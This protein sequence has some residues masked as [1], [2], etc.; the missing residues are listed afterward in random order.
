M[1]IGSDHNAPTYTTDSTTL[2]LHQ[3]G[4]KLHFDPQSGSL[5]YSNTQGSKELLSDSTFNYTRFQV[6]TKNDSSLRI[7]Y[8]DVGLRCLVIFKNDLEIKVKFESTEPQTLCWPKVSISKAKH[9]FIWPK[10]GGY[11]IPFSDTLFANKFDG[12]NVNATYLSL[13]FWAVEK[14]SATSM[15]EMVNPFHT[16]ILFDN[17]DSTMSLRVF[18]RYTSNAA[19]KEPYEIKIIH[20]SNHSPITPALHF[21]KQLE[22]SNDLVSLAQKIESV[23]V[24]KRMIGALY[25]KLVSIQFITKYDIR[26]GKCIALA[27]AIVEDVQ[28]HKGFVA[29]HWKKLEPNQRDF[30][31][32]IAHSEKLNKY[33]EKVFIQIL[34]ALLKE[35]GVND[36]FAKDKRKNAELLY[37]DYSEYLLPPEQWG[38]GVSIRMINALEDAGINR[39]ILR[40]LGH[41]IAFDRK[42]VAK[43]AFDQGYLFGVYD[44]YLSIHDLSTYGTDDSWET[45][46]MPEVIFD[47]V[48]M[49]Q[50]NGFHYP[51]FK[52]RGGI[53]NPKVIRSYYEKRINNNFA[54]VPYSYY[55]IDVDAFGGYRDDY[56][57]NHPLTQQEDAAQRLDRLEW[58]KTQKQVPVGSEKGTYLFSNVL[59]INEGVAVPIFGLRDKEMR[60]DERSKYYLGRY[61]PPEMIEIA[62][63]EVLLKSEYQHLHF[64]L[65]F[66]IPLWETVYHDCL[67]STA[68]HSSP[69]LKYSNVKTD[70]ALTEMFYQY[71]PLYNLNFDFFQNNKDRI[72]HHYKFYSYTHPKTV[73]FPVTEFDFLTKDR[74]VQR[75]QFGNIQLVA[76]YASTF[77]KF[78]EYDIP[79]KSILFIDENG[80][81]SYFDPEKF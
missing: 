39:M 53:A 59:D 7:N 78:K 21:R 19:L 6:Q 72:V 10:N 50:E 64:D 29:A 11:Y 8:P 58:L 35:E 44:E 61:W 80:N 74:L 1:I 27:R 37:A 24:S 4:Y 16:T 47:S 62:F 49:K 63:K 40:T 22:E 51:G 66:K 48:S 20:L 13:P 65:R 43:H 14:D 32:Q 70:V 5:E 38:D 34:G 76:N 57:K 55:F 79:G 41:Q 25:A 73:K 45:A 2:T 77:Y 46:Q 68:H 52:S 17:E 67:I 69:S 36:E 71:P 31:K 9:F 12:S 18:H 28:N 3:G 26:E 15:Y 75:I 42:E 81:H 54:E 30:I 23:P 60:E 33:Q 56:S